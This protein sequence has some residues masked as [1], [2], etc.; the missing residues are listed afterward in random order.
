[1][2]KYRKSLFIFRR[3]LRLYD[4]TGL[5]A[6]LTQSKQV[7]ACFIFDPRQIE[8]HP[9]Q[10][11][12]GLQFMLQSLA[13]L[14]GQLV[15]HGGRLFLFNGLPEPIISQIQRDHCIEAIFVNRDYTPFSRQRDVGLCV[16]SVSRRGFATTQDDSYDS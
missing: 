6:A 16:D 8:P 11:G 7:L 13:D 1:M 15:R 9:Y 14:R 3:D 4:N 2:N 10:S 12:P 5:N